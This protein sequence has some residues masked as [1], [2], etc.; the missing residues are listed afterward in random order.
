MATTKS[1]EFFHLDRDASSVRDAASGGVFAAAPHSRCWCF[2]TR[3][4]KIACILLALISLAALGVIIWIVAKVVA[5]RQYVNGMCPSASSG[6]PDR[7]AGAGTGTTVIPSYYPPA[8]G[9]GAWATL[10]PEAAGFSSQRLKSLADYA[11]SQGM[12]RSL[13]IVKGGMLLWESCWGDGSASIDT[14]TFWASAQKSFTSA[15]TLAV[16]SQGKLSLTTPVANLLGANWAPGD[17]APSVQSAVTVRQ[18]LS[19]TSSLKDGFDNKW[20][21][22]SSLAEGPGNRWRYSSVYGYLQKVVAAATQTSQDNS[23]T[24]KAMQ[25]ALFSPIGMSRNVRVDDP[26]ELLQT[27]PFAMK[28]LWKNFWATA[29]DGARLG[30][31]FARNGTWNE[32]QLIQSDLVVAATSSSSPFNLAYGFLF[33]LNGKASGLQPSGKVISGPFLPNCPPDAYAAIGAN[34]QYVAVIPSLDVVL[35][36]NGCPGKSDDP[37]GDAEDGLTPQGVLEELCKRLQAAKL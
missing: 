3:P 12:S 15:A 11:A 30:L 28:S 14:L 36:R 17:V 23:G 6:Q 27:P 33:W 29:R 16:V 8:H 26:P 24:V 37:S 19:M 7:C 31:L 35:V 18:L 21:S 9:S 1:L 34:G 20:N 2:R 32:Q 22:F 4:R 10:Q 5:L 13:V 25:S